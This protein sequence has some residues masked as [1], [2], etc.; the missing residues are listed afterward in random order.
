MLLEIDCEVE[1]IM[2]L[3]PHRC[4]DSNKNSNERDTK[5][6]GHEIGNIY[7]LAEFNAGHREQRKPSNIKL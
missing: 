5:K 6:R 1:Q 4:N 3:H 7:R 2:S